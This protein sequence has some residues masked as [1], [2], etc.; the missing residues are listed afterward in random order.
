M[1][2]SKGKRG[3]RGFAHAGG[4]LA[5]RL[6]EAGSSRGFSET[7]IL[8][9]WA[10]IVGPEIARI[11]KPAKVG[12]AKSGLGATLTIVA[13]GA[14]GPELQMQVPTIRERVNACYGYNAI[15]RV[16]I[17]Q[18]DRHAGFAEQQTAF[19][20][21]KPE[22]PTADP[23]KVAALGL[24]NVKDDGLRQA[25]EQLSTSVLSKPQRQNRT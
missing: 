15:S 2:Q 5:R 10:E 14:H 20:S 12:F 18:V 6:R 13:S 24:D 7:R 9:N 4:L 11:A 23:T 19:D 17:T 22:T 3:T 25:L 8:T 16:R 21:P 1:A